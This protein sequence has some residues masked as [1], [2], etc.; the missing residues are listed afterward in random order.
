[1]KH[2][3]K[4]EGSILIISNSSAIQKLDKKL[5]KFLNSK[6]PNRSTPVQISES[7]SGLYFK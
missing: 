6:L 3:F 7:T 5:K 1:M 4:L 2:N